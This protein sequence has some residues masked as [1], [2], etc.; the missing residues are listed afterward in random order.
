VQIVK[1]ITHRV[2]Q[3]ALDR[4]VPCQVI[5]NKWQSLKPFGSSLANKRMQRLLPVTLEVAI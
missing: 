5:D 3:F 4:T 2:K 1:S